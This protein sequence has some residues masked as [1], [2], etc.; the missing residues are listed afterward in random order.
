MTP[1]VVV[2]A[3]VE[4]DGRFLVTRRLAGTHLEGYWE[5]PGGKCEAGESD[6]ACLA[7]EMREELGVEVQVGACL[8]RAEYAYPERTVELRF[9]ACRIAGVPVARLGQDIRWV[10]RDELSA[11][12]FPPADAGLIARLAGTPGPPDDRRRP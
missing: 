6:A 11:L 3:V 2:A 9:Y 12:P 10:T 7:R 4:E 8:H 5:F 1:T